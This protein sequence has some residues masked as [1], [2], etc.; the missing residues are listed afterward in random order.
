M[1]AFKELERRSSSGGTKFDNVLVET[2][3]VADPGPVVSRF[4]STLVWERGAFRIAFG[5]EE[6]KLV[7]LGGERAWIGGSEIVGGLRSAL[8]AV[9]TGENLD[10]RLLTFFFEASSAFRSLSRALSL[11]PRIFFP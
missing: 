4:F 8:V 11:P 7:F 1:D 9:E 6:G 3:G 5:G 10:V 2:T